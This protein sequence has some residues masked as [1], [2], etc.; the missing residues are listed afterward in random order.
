MLVN[1]WTV[2]RVRAS[3][4]LC[5]TVLY[6]VHTPEGVWAGVF[7][8]WAEAMTWATNP[9]ER[10]ECWLANQPRPRKGYWGQDVEKHDDE[11]KLL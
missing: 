10:L 6:D 9:I 1:R 2:R 5:N 4:G 7:D 8:T 11:G 3:T